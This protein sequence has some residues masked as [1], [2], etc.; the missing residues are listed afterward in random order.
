MIAQ[1]VRVRL[2]RLRKL[3][4]LVRLVGTAD[5]AQLPLNGEALRT[6]KSPLPLHWPNKR[7]VMLTVNDAPR[8]WQEMAVRAKCIHHLVL[9]VGGQVQGK[10]G[11]SGIGCRLIILPPLNLLEEPL[12]QL[13]DLLR[14]SRRLLDFIFRQPPK[15]LK[16]DARHRGRTSLTLGLLT[17][18]RSPLYQGF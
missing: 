9:V 17:C 11:L 6:I 8:T 15:P 13:L 12:F 14:I 18:S 2:D 1:L 10:R 4:R 7:C 5:L 3:L 16:I